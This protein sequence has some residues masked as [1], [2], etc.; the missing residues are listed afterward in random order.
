MAIPPA[1]DVDMDAVVPL[2]EAEIVSGGDWRHALARLE[3]TASEQLTVLRRL[4]DGV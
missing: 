3:L 2:L 1:D 4:G